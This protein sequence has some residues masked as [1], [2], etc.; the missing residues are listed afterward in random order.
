MTRYVVPVVFIVEAEGEGQA[1]SIKKSV[2]AI[3]EELVGEDEPPHTL[4]EFAV[5]HVREEAFPIDEE[6]QD[7]LPRLPEVRKP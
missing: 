4:R 1:S 6:E 7:A 2:Q 3:L 5:G